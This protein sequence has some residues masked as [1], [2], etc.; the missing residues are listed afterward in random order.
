MDCDFAHARNGLSSASFPYAAVCSV[1]RAAAL[2]RACRDLRNRLDRHGPEA[3]RILRATCGCIYLKDHRVGHAWIRHRLR[4]PAGI[5]GKRSEI[6]ADIADTPGVRFH[7]TSDCR[8][9]DG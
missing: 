8:V 2:L 5:V 1:G 3:W 7:P 6:G 4:A 9:S